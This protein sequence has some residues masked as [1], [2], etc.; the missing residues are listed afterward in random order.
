[1]QQFFV[2]KIKKIQ[3]KINYILTIFCEMIYNKYSIPI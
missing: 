3:K 1:M 2:I